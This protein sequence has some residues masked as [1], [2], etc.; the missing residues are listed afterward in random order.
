MRRLKD[1]PGCMD[2]DSSQQRLICLDEQLILLHLAKKGCGKMGTQHH[3][4]LKADFLH[5][6][7]PNDVEPRGDASHLAFPH[8]QLNYSQLK[9]AYVPELPF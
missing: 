8:H 7:T 9:P 5:V 2:R 4:L 3:F 6:N 1:D